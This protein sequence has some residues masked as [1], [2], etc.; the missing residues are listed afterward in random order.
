MPTR[1]NSP[2]CLGQKHAI[3]S[4]TIKFIDEQPKANSV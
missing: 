4:N 3:L 1:V 2:T